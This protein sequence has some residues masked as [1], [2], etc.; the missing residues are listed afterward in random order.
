MGELNKKVLMGDPIAKQVYECIMVE[1]G[2]LDALLADLR[3]YT[4]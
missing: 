4:H 1:V 2:E 3:T